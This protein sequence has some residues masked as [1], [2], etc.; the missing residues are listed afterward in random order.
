[1]AP[2][3]KY[4]FVL[5]KVS[6][7]HFELVAGRQQQQMAVASGS[8]V[9][10]AAHLFSQCIMVWRSLARARIPLGS[11]VYS[12]FFFFLQGVSVCPRG[13][14]WFISGVAEQYCVMLWAHL[15]GLLVALSMFGA[16]IQ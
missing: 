3:G 9:G 13:L 2:A 6:Q 16:G 7:A 12:V 5:Q 4:L 15:F 10:V 1:V 11:I 8:G 14:C